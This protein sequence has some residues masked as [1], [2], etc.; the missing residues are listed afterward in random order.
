MFSTACLVFL[1]SKY[2][3]LTFFCNSDENFYVEA[4]VG[5]HLCEYF[6]SAQLAEPLS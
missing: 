3:T 6:P 4:F 5:S 1:I 2:S